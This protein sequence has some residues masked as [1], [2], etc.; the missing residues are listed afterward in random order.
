[1]APSKPWYHGG[2]RFSCTEC[3]DCCRVEGHVWVDA[4]EIDAL[5]RHL[6]LTLNAFGRSFLRRVGDRLSLVEKANRDCIF[7]ENGCTVYPVRPRQCRTFPFWP[8]NVADSAGWQS[9]AEECEGIGQGRLYEPAEIETL[10]T[11]RGSTA[12]SLRSVGKT[13]DEPALATGIPSKD[14]SGG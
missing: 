14:S 12:A 5:A 6:G 2:L 1:M 7:W 8:D 9:A 11:G 13:D 10:S 4:L 3:G